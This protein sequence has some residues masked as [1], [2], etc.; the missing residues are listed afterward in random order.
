MFLEN[1][2]QMLH[3]ENNNVF[4][5]LV[6]NAPIT[7]GGEGILSGAEGERVKKRCVW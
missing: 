6:R 4:I 1:G 3:V 2:G 5:L 7:H